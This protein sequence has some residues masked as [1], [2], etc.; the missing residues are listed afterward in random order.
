M[1]EKVGSYDSAKTENCLSYSKIYHIQRK[2]VTWGGP[3]DRYGIATVKGG[4]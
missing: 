1:D 3:S 2:K 4:Y